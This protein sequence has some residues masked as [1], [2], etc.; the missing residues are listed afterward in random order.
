MRIDV[1]SLPLV[2]AEE[3][4]QGL[5]PAGKEA[6]FHHPYFEPLAHGTVDSFQSDWKIDFLAMLTHPMVS[7]LIFLGLF[8]GFYMELSS[9]GFGFPGAVG[10][11]CL[12]LVLLSS[13]ALQA[14]SWL[15][16]ILI[17]AGLILLALELFVIPGFGVAGL[18]GIIAIVVGLFAL[19]LPGLENVTFDTDSNTWNA[20]GEVFLERLVWL[21]GSLVVGT[22]VI[23][24]LG[25]YVLPR[26]S[27][28]NRLV[29]QGEEESSQGYVAGY[30]EADLPSVGSQGLV[31]ATLRPAGKVVI[32]GRLYDAMSAGAFIEGGTPIHVLRI[33]G[34]K[35]IVTAQNSEIET[36]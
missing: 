14:A 28:L 11:L 12:F 18:G 4:A 8:I 6:L 3:E 10:L 17:F 1:V 30:S 23:G 31:A 7:S 20:A 5:W 33:K 9:P 27:A 36:P 2:T 19:M 25:R 34:G 21:C 32:D 13:F 16:I 35:L 26:F 24:L 22:I 29:L 15:E